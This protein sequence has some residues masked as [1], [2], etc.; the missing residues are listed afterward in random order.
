MKPPWGSKTPGGLPKSKTSLLAW[1]SQTGNHQSILSKESTKQVFSSFAK[2]EFKKLSGTRFWL[3][4]LQSPSQRWVGWKPYKDA[5]QF[6][7]VQVAIAFPEMGGLKNLGKFVDVW[8]TERSSW[9][10]INFEWYSKLSNIIVQ[11]SIYE[12]K[13]TLIC[14]E[15]VNF[16]LAT[17][18]CELIRK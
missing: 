18:I 15:Q 7:E 17:L 1:L 16:Y 11:I 13:A 3:R 5:F 14:E 4:E 2:T 8:G 10:V 12:F 6:S 9:F